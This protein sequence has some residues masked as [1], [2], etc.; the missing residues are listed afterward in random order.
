M[1]RIII[2]KDLGLLHLGGRVRPIVKAMF[3]FHDYLDKILGIK[4][5]CEPSALP[6]A[7]ADVDWTLKAKPALGQ[8]YMNNALGCCVVAGSLH[9]KGIWTGNSDTVEGGQIFPDS[10]VPPLYTLL[11]G[12]IFDPANPQATDSGC[13]EVTALNCLTNTGYPDGNKITGFM[14]VDASNWSHVQLAHWLFEGLM[15]GSELSD[16]AV[17]NIPSSDGASWD[18]SGTPEPKNGHCMTVA[19]VTADTVTLGTW[20]Q[21]FVAQRTAVQSSMV[22]SAGGNLYAL[23]SDNIIAR[24][25]AKAPTGFDFAQLQTDMTSLQAGG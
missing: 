16:N 15:T 5:N 23:L 3:S 13:D 9:L 1:G 18:I 6:V 14:A 19:R 11:S 24:A 4:Q 2:H 20:G 25:T 21:L 12:G 7:P 10:V 17:N 8:M 22:T